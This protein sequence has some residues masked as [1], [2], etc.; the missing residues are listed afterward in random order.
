[1]A[2]GS[3]IAPNASAAARRTFS[4]PIAIPQ[5]LD[6]RGHG[7]GVAEFAQRLRCR[8]A[9]IPRSLSPSA[10]MSAGTAWGSP[11]SPNASA[12]AQRTS[13]PSPSAWM[14]AGTAWGSPRSS[15]T[16]PLPPSEHSHRSLSPSAWM[17]AGTAWGSP[18]LPNA[19]A[20]ARRTF[21]LQ[22][23][24]AFMSA[25]TAWGSPS[26]P[27]ASAAARRTSQSL[28]PS[29]WMSAGTAWGSPIAPNAHAAAGEQPNRYPPALG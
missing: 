21:S 3:P 24:S 2:W 5:C 10:W 28:S 17:S 7:L 25:G 15:P 20:A 11:R 19:S 26:L 9:N 27:N 18:I 22:S 13:Y 14:S 23:P 8:T 1:M 16:P 12:A 6:E 29:A 4:L